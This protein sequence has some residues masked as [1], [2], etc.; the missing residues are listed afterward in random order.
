MV[1][2]GFAVLGTFAVFLIGRQMELFRINAMQ[3]K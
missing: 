2:V 3:K 1:F